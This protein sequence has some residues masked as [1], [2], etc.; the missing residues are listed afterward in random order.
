MLSAMFSGLHSI[1][2]P[3]G[4]AINI[5][6]ARKG[7]LMMSDVFQ[8]VTQF[9]C[10][11]YAIQGDVKQMFWQIHLSEKDE[12][13]HGVICNGE[14]LVFTRVSFG[15]KPS[16]PIADNCMK[17]IAKL[18]IGKYPLGSDILLNKRYVDDLLDSSS[19]LEIIANKRNETTE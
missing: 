7:Q 17:E 3:F 5:W 2:G 19:D 8:I 16:P 9:R 11:R 18:G 4:P 15:G 10:G 14:T 1:A 6:L 13:Y 12:C